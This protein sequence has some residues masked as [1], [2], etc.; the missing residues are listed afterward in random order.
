[1]SFLMISSTSFTRA[2]FSQ[3][4][5]RYLL[6]PEVRICLLWEN[7]EELITAT[8]LQSI[9]D[10][11]RERTLSC[12]KRLLRASS[13]I[14]CDMSSGTIWNIS[15]ECT[16]RTRWKGRTRFGF[17]GISGEIERVENAIRESGLYLTANTDGVMT[18]K[19]YREYDDGNNQK[20]TV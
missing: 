1:M 11:L 3:K 4:R 6:T 19:H 15:P 7:T 20:R 13:E 14:Q 9:T 8:K 10:R 16:E 12:P 5:L 2:C 17:E 18:T